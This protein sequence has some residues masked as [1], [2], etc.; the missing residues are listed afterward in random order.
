MNALKA[1]FF[2]TQVCEEWASSPYTDA[3]R[4]KIDR[5]MRV[6]GISRG[7]RI[8][9]PGCGTGRLTDILSDVA[10][11][12]GQVVAVD[13]SS[14]MLDACM[15][16]LKEPGKVHLVHGG[17]E[18]AIPGPSGFDVAVCHNVFPQFDD[19]ALA[20]QKLAQ[21]LTQ[22]GRL[23]IFHFYESRE[24]NN[25]RRKTHDIVRKDTLPTVG[26]FEAIFSD[27]GLAIEFLS[28]DSDGF[29]LSATFL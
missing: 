7:T 21:T 24:V 16:R 13:T 19:K 25:P 3:E 28:D 5:M 12:S 2:N 8:L 9:E 11:P 23:V 27:A 29:L 17:I 10:G 6:A 22:T 20:A 1:E 26:E 18:D 14:A 15:K 4:R